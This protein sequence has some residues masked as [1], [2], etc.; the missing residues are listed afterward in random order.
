MF[1]EDVFMAIP[2]YSERRPG[3]NKPVKI[4]RYLNMSK[5]ARLIAEHLNTLTFIILDV[6]REK[7]AELPE[8]EPSEV[9]IEKRLYES[10]PKGMC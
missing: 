7:V 9:P 5:Y 10:N 4:I 2:S 6:E 8:L 3:Q 1:A